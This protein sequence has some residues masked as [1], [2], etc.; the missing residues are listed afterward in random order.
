[1]VLGAIC[2]NVLNTYSRPHRER[3]QSKTL[4]HDPSV[5][6]CFPTHPDH[7]RPDS[8][9]H[10]LKLWRLYLLYLHIRMYNLV[11][12]TPMHDVFLTF[13]W[14]VQLTPPIKLP[15]NVFFPKPL[16]MRYDKLSLLL[17]FLTANQTTITS[18]TADGKREREKSAAMERRRQTSA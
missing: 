3:L 9:G 18:E 13:H 15:S 6:L 2:H 10:L 16:N 8:K 5:I 17:S 1:M 7:L 14:S 12:C 11:D 4:K